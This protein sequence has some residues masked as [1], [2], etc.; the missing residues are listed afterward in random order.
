MA[1]AAWTGDVL[2][3][4][5]GDLGPDDWFG[6]GAEL[7]QRIR[8]RFAGLYDRLAQQVPGEAY[9]Q[10]EPALAAVILFDQMPRNM[11]RGT[12]QAFSTDHLALGVA[13]NALDR[14]FDTEMPN[15]RRMF[16]YMPF[17]HSEKLADQERCVELFGTLN[18]ENG[19]KYAEEH[20]DIVA[21]Y[22]RFPHRN[23][24]LGRD[25]SEAERE[26]LGAHKGY[27]Q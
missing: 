22:G 20:R 7:D 11:F 8:D 18:N 5:F 13:A 10:A 27:G 1:E 21:K 6:G 12:G 23:R 16:L 24:A 2:N 4:W 17:M 26:F 14:G 15:P 3:F 19:L 25:S 9:D